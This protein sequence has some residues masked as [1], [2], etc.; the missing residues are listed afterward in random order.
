MLS[1]SQVAVQRAFA[2]SARVWHSPKR[3]ASAAELA[4]EAEAVQVMFEDSALPYAA[5]AGS[6]SM[7]P[8]TQDAEAGG[9]PYLGI[10][11]HFA[12]NRGK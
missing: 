11:H 7:Q 8:T 2:R 3:S 5:G 1:V 6:R 9:H 12:A 4:P 10:G